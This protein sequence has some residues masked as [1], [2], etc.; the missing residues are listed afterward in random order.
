MSAR[1]VR[2]LTVAGILVLSVASATS[3]RAQAPGSDKG[4]AISKVERLNRA[5]VSKE[6]LTVHLPKPT[7]HKLPNGLT[8]LIL[9]QHKL[10]TVAFELSLRPGAIADPSPSMADFTADM[11]TEGSNSFERRDRG[12]GGRNGRNIAC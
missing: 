1:R 3:I 5:P 11:L 12:R 2:L 8:V 4:M 7:E 9:E 6:I 10:P